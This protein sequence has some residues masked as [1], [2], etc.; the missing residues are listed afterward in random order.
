M[1]TSMF[2]DFWK[3]LTDIKK[4]GICAL[5]GFLVGLIF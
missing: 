2:E 4:C 3:E 5:I 1:K